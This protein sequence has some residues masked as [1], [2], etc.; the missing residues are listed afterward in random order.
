MKSCFVYILS[1]FKSLE[2]YASGENVSINKIKSNLFLLQRSENKKIP[3]HYYKSRIDEHFKNIKNLS[4]FLLSSLEKIFEEFLK[5]DKH[6]SLIYANDNT[7]SEWQNT[8]SFIPPLVVQCC[9]I[10]KQYNSIGDVQLY[11]DKYHVPNF[12]YTAI[13]KPKCSENRF[14][15]SKFSGFN[16]L[17]LHL[18][19]SVEIDNAWQDF[20]KFPQKIY[21]DLKTGYKKINVEEHIEQDSHLLKPL[22]FYNYLI[23]AVNIRRILFEIIYNPD[24][25][26]VKNLLNLPK[27]QLLLNIIFKDM[28]GKGFTSFKHPFLVLLENPKADISLISVEALM[29]VCVFDHLT[30]DNKNKELIA[31][32]FHIYLLIQGI[33]NKLLVQQENQYGF[34]Q[35]Q[36]HTFNKLRDLNEKTFH[37][38]FF[39]MA[40]NMNKNFKYLEGRFSP[41][42]SEMENVV[43]FTSIEKGW[44]KFQ[45]KSEDKQK[46]QKLNLVAHF[47]KTPD[48]D[49]CPW[50]KYKNLRIS[51][52]KQAFILDRLIKK[53][54]YNRLMIGIDAAANELH[55]PPEVFSPVFRRLRRSNPRLKLTYHA[56]EDFFHPISG[57][58]AIYEAFLFLELKEHDRIG[59]ATASGILWAQWKKELGSTILIKKGEWL[60]NLA[61]VYYL[62]NSRK[63]A[64]FL[65]LTDKVTTLFQELSYYIYNEQV[66]IEQYIEAWKKRKYCPILLSIDSFEEAYLNPIFDTYEWR[67]L[68]DVKSSQQTLMLLKLY[69]RSDVRERCAEFKEL[70]ID[71]LIT[72]SQFEKLQLV[73][74]KKINR[75]KVILETLPTSNVRISHYQNHSQ[76]HILKWLEW[77]NQGHDIPEIVIGSDDT[78]IFSTNI[79]NEY[80][81]VYSQLHNSE[82][83]KKNAALYMQEIIK[84][85]E[86]F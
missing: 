5:I 12:L 57:L 45:F 8:I 7:Y 24:S 37:Q 19:G 66:S 13:P 72:A 70:E 16:E 14:T 50:V 81:H 78:G 56:G 11:Y 54:P 32:F 33:S 49:K 28:P 75:A 3:D 9:G 26:E 83:L 77:K 62:I 21:K 36:K 10:F 74:L 6:N 84:S 64:F 53:P 38:R 30:N 31:M 25:E 58:R 15:S 47:I 43:L 48:D 85:S 27:D 68:I 23:S 41:K 59:H 17:H 2:L 52:F 55:T 79:H 73:V 69:N 82:E 44:K 65:G 1:D 4:G 67:N 86:R 20:L 61:F 51:I 46:N 34:D 76:H 29:Y 71:S 60:D 80:M 22:K 42:N 39:Q 63:D 35:F 40:G 18:N